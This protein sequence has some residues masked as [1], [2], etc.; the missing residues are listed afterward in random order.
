[1]AGRPK[2]RAKKIARGECVCPAL[3]CPIH[4][5]ELARATASDTLP[6][7]G[8][9]QWEEMLERARI[10]AAQAPAPQTLAEAEEQTLNRLLPI[11]Y[12]VIE[13]QLSDEDARV[14]QKAALEV[15]E[16]VKGKAPQTVRM[17]GEQTHTVR[18]ESAAWT[19]G[20]EIVEQQGEIE[21]AD[22][23]EIEEATG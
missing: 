4:K 15:I 16:R 11:A 13:E 21:E 5:T 2:T 19:W 1:M 8:S 14:R 17:T 3:G 20:K 22:F 18:Y 23:E 9:L 7:P 6:S 10:E 12:G